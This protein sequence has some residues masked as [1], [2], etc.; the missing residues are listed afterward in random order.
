[1]QGFS[2]LIYFD[3]G[4]MASFGQEATR[5]IALAHAVLGAVMF[6]WGLMLAI[7]VRT[8]FA[9]GQRMGWN[10]VAV[11]VGAWFI[12]DTSYSLI[13]GFWQNAVLNSAF[14]FLFLVPLVATRKVFR[15]VGTQ[16]VTQSDSLERSD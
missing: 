5:Y 9:A 3:Q 2:L 13:S 14:L 7:V 11:S 16:P 10:M 15:P 6:G 4:K 8:L 12:P 1:M